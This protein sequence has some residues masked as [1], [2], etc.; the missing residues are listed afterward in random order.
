M[1]LKPARDPD[2]RFVSLPVINHVQCHLTKLCQNDKCFWRQRDVYGRNPW[3]HYQNPNQNDHI[4]SKF[5]SPYFPELKVQTGTNCITV[6][7][8]DFTWE[9]G[10]MY[11]DIKDFS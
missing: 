6:F 11:R 7:C 3:Y 2:G 9:D 1:S 5:G 8:E 4:D 10:K